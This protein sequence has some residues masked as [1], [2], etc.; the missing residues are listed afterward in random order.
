M[1][2]YYIDG[3]AVI[4]NKAM[5]I[6]DY[7]IDLTSD[8]SPA[9]LLSLVGQNKR[10]LEVGC[11]AGVQTRILV[12][13]LNCTVTGI[14]INPDAAREA[15]RYC[16]EVICG[17]IEQLDLLGRFAPGAFDVV[18]FADVLE[19]LR[20]PSAVLEKIRPLLA[21]G[22]AVLASIP[23]IVH[24]ALVME[25]VRG[26]FDYRNFGLL[27][28][29]HI[30]FFTLKGVCKL[31]EESGYRLTHIER[32][33]LVPKDTEFAVT[34]ENDR[35]QVV[36]DYIKEINPE[37]QTYQ[38]VVR[39]IATDEG[40]V[41]ITSELI[42]V[43]EKVQSLERQLDTATLRANKAESKLHWIENHGGY[44]LFRKFKVLFGLIIFGN[45]IF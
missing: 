23:N 25:M 15:G 28:D 3:G 41:A 27:D 14:E 29:T 36:L 22:G 32:A 19:H 40:E 20:D 17:D 44:K 2:C 35:E 26:R 39:A 1:M 13:S 9:R 11:S 16:S 24:A 33:V 37:W 5:K 43:Q 4:P 42:E 6:Y 34:A 45:V 8:A 18:I 10:V 31:F 7:E 38:F 30:R 21:E 12:E